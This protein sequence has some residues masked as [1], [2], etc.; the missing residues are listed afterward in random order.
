MVNPGNDGV[1]IAGLFLNGEGRTPAVIDQWL[2]I[3]FCPVGLIFS[4]V[5]Y[6]ASERV[7]TV[8]KHIRFNGNRLTDCPL[9]REPASVDLRAD[10]FND[11]PPSSIVR[12]R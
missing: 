10:A 11:H 5:E 6:L 4:F 8:G 12:L 3:D 7:V 1:A 9:D 2:H